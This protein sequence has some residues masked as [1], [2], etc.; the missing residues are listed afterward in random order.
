MENNKSSIDFASENFPLLSPGELHLWIVSTAITSDQYDSYKTSLSEDE[1]AQIQY[2]QFERARE[3]FVV[4][5]SVL[6]RLL[7]GYIGIDP[8]YLMLG[9]KSKGKPYSINEPGLFFN[10]SHSG[11]IAVIAFSRDSEVGID[12]EKIR[13]LPDL[14]EMIAKNFTANETKFI[15]SRPDE[16][17]NRFFRFWTVKES[18]LKAIGEGMRLTPDSVE[19]SFEHDHFQQ[20]SVKGIFEMEDWNFKEFTLGENYTGT[21]T[22]GLASVIIKQMEF[23]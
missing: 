23:N 8:P 10:M 22:Y 2:F 16:K 5:Q 1:L 9:K 6:R 4:S 7:S 18:Y 3:S 17:I 11:E 19:F 14:D 20:L 21:V 15:N 12:I 13:T